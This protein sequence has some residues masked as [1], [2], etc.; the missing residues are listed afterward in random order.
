MDDLSRLEEMV[1]QAV[2]RL[3]DEAYGVAIRKRLSER[4][5]RIFPYGTLYSILEALLRKSFVTCRAGEPTPKRGG[6]SK[7][8]YR[9]TPEGI[10]ALKAALE[11]SKIL[12]DKNTELALTRT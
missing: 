7:K 5:G 10:A 11:L 3:K 6:R 9:I 1:L 12:W 2:W 4:T 8:Y